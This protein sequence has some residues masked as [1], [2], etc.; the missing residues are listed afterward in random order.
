MDPEKR[1]SQ[2][3][4]LIWCLGRGGGG[5]KEGRVY[6]NGARCGPCDMGC[7]WHGHSGGRTYNCRQ[8]VLVRSWE[9]QGR[10][11]ARPGPLKQRMGALG[12]GKRA[13]GLQEGIEMTSPP[14]LRS[15]S[16][17]LAEPRFPY[18]KWTS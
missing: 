17:S 7:R 12:E 1:G 6:S 14:P 16:I 18:A 11:T 5:T 15:P 9:G 2:G 13:P 10:R 4:F 8:E 3:S